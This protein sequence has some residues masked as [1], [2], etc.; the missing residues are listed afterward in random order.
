MKNNFIRNCKLVLDL[1]RSKTCLQTQTAG[2]A[3]TASLRV[4]PVKYSK[5]GRKIVDIPA[6]MAL[7]AE[8]EVILAPLRL[9]VKEQGDLVRQLKADGK[10]EIEVKKAV[11]ELKTRKKVMEEKEVSLRPSLA[12]FDRTKMEDTLKRRFFYDQSFAIYGGVTGQY[13]FGPMGCAMKQNLLQAWRKHFVL[14]EQMLEVDCTVLTPEPIL[15]ASG[16]VARF[17]DLMVKDMKNGECFRL[18]HLIKAA[19][20]KV[21]AE[22]KTSAETKVECE[23]IVVRLD[24]MT[25]EE[26]AAVMKKFDMKAPLTNNPLSEPIEFNL[27]FQTH[28]GPSGAI[29]GFL[30]PETAQGIFVNFK[31]LLEF[32]QGKLP[33]AAAQIGNA[34]RNEISPR[35]GLIRVREFT[36]AEIE[37]FCD[38]EDKSHPKFSGVTSTA[39]TLY[40]A[41]N[42][43]G[44]EAAKLVNIGDAVSS[45]MVA[46]ETL[47]YFMVRI[48]QFLL[49]MGVDNGRLRFRQHMANEM[50]HYACDC[51][52]AELLT[53]YG[54]V[55]CVGCADRSAYDL[56][57]HSQATG[58]KLCAEK[59]LPAPVTRDI[60]EIVPNKGAIGKA[61]KKE[62]KSVTDML[63]KLSLEQIEKVEADLAGGEASL[64]MDGKPVLLSKDMVSVKKYQKTF[65]VEEI[66]P[67]VIEP[68]FGIG[69]VM[70]AIFEHNFKVREG[71][72]QRTYFSLP[73]VIA[74][75]K[76]SLLPLS[77]NTDFTPLVHKIGQALTLHDISHRVDDSSGSIGKRYA[78]TDEVSIPFGITVDFD[79]LK[80]PHSVTLR[81]RDTTTQIRIDVDKVAEV[82]Y[83]LS[84]GRTTWA[85]VTT[86]FP[87][88]EAQ[89]TKS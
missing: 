57:Q 50:A 43:M 13:D 22:K 29:R 61:F 18:D 80:E 71:D 38:P 55:E 51:W 49:K 67:S 1:S 66:I 7:S 52:D 23:D 70:Y 45:G 86:Q 17:A 75:V 48:Q 63:A 53:S 11:A 19:L 54:W 73:P 88:F 3:F 74:P 79:S 87:K 76:C 60:M 41:N 6:A 25:K 5:K 56:T 15:E 62:A 24:G 89:E 4:G 47:G 42:Q 10:P 33:F 16:H 82:I 68:S 34:F 46:N 26:M 8:S 40:S 81:E 85:V 37:H 39:L 30:R 69:R 9:A 58:V 32:N 65:H 20:E 83:Q 84:T 78:R 77:N 35:A 72:E 2:L 31:R 28:I 59:R 21:C 64:E 27:M 14:E 12:K 44:G 36:M